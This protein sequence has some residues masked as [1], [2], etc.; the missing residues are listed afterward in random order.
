MAKIDFYIHIFSFYVHASQGI[1]KYVI[2]NI[3]T[4]SDENYTNILLGKCLKNMG[5]TYQ[6]EDSL[7][8]QSVINDFY[9]P[10]L[11]VG[12]FKT[13]NSTITKEEIQNVLQKLGY[14]LASIYLTKEEAEQLFKLYKD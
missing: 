8:Y 12:R 3:A 4:I 14:N 1:I 13:C 9:D 6:A 7:S 11:K 2:H 10:R 5:I